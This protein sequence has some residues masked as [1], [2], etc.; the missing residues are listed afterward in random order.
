MARAPGDVR[1]GRAEIT[2]RSANPGDAEAIARLLGVLG[3]PT[4]PAQVAPRLAAM[5]S[6]G[7]IVR[8]AERNGGVVALVTARTS[9]SI[10]DDE[11]V[12][13]LT[14]LVVD[15][16]QQGQG[17]GAA[18][19]RDVEAWA[20]ERGASRIAVTSAS[21]RVAAHRFYEGLG[22]A[23]TGVRLGRRID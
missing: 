20:R 19:V 11:P 8:L 4:T 14:T 15:A 21:R 13:W 10:H 1:A 23:V 18:L 12:A 3:Y 5:D 9:A 6:P 16:D 2:I 17:I 22:Y 7:S